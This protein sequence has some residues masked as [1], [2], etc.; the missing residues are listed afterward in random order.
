MQLQTEYAVAQNCIEYVNMFKGM[1]N[2][3]ISIIL[4]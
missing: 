2:T 1:Q 3:I 4:Y